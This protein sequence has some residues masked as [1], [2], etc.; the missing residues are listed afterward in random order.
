[1]LNVRLFWRACIKTTPTRLPYVPTQ[2]YRT[3][4][5]F[6]WNNNSHTFCYLVM[7]FQWNLLF[8]QL[9][10]DC[11]QIFWLLL[12]K[13]VLSF[14]GSF[15]TFG[16]VPFI[17]ELNFGRQS[18]NYLQGMTANVTWFLSFSYHSLMMASRAMMIANLV[19]YYPFIAIGARCAQRG[20]T[21][22]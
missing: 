6:L 17:Q 5:K 4:N 10:N 1:M 14:I 19:I 16:S 13:L 3:K 8:F 2:P 21:A 12:G 7:P 9:E 22:I 20:V 11:N 15:V 18:S